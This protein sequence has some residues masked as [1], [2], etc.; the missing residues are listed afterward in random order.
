MHPTG[1]HFQ[2]E[3]RSQTSMKFHIIINTNQSVV[4]ILIWTRDSRF[5]VFNQL[6]KKVGQRSST[7]SQYKEFS[8]GRNK[9]TGGRQHHILIETKDLEDNIFETKELEEDNIINQICLCFAFYDLIYVLVFFL[10]NSHCVYYLKLSKSSGHNY[11]SLT[12]VPHLR[13]QCDTSRGTSYGHQAHC[14]SGI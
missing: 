9:G 14:S 7:R 6:G 1:G 11:W 2:K 12:Y 10:V 8:A 13:T 3:M 4:Q 5:R